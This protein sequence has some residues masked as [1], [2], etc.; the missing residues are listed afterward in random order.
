MH[1]QPVMPLTVSEDSSYK[2]NELTTGHA[3]LALFS[4]QKGSSVFSSL[5][6]HCSVLFSFLCTFLLFKCILDS[7]E[8]EYI[9]SVLLS[10][11]A[12]RK[13]DVTSELIWNTTVK[14]GLQFSDLI[15]V[16]CFFLRTFDAIFL[17]KLFC[18]PRS[19]HCLFSMSEC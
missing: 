14:R 18:K 10:A 19:N 7:K 4:K 9:Y 11:T 8:A 15:K 17:V 2:N 3:L 13:T 1:E 16:C 5:D 12:W 6:R